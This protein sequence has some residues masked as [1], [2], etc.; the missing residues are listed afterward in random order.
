ML[1]L[2]F[3]DETWRRPTVKTILVP[4]DG[5]VCAEQALPYVLVLAPLLK[6]RVRLVRIVPNV[7]TDQHVLESIAAFAGATPTMS[8]DYSARRQLQGELLEQS[9]TYLD[10]Q[11]NLLRRAGLVCDPVTYV[12]AAAHEL[13]EQAHDDAVIMV[14]MGTHGYTGVRRWTVGSVADKVVHTASKP[15]LLVRSQ[16][17]AVVTAPKPLRHI[18]VPLDGSALSARALPLATQIAKAANASV[19]LFRAIE[20]MTVPFPD[21][22]QV[23]STLPSYETFMADVRSRAQENLEQVTTALHDQQIRAASHVLMGAP[24]EAIVDEAQRQQVDMIVMAT[25]GYTGVQR[26]AMGSVADKVLHA[27]TIP[28]LLVPVRG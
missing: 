7:D 22:R 8:H 23:G 26:W 16:Q 27:T 19:Q 1:R 20:P 11:A 25:H 6:A 13:V 17:D 10:G 12:G 18:L 2:R 9:V 15:V 3:N 4:L 5:S 14:I 24:A 28:L 21:V